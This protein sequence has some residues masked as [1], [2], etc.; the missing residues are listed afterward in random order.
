MY[1]HLITYST[2]INVKSSKK[3]ER[4]GCYVEKCEK[5]CINDFH[6]AGKKVE[7]DIFFID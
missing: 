4:I 1:V 7:M 2:A 5:I 3:V 6:Y